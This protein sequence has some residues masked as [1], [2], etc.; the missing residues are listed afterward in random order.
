MGR[1]ELSDLPD[2]D[3]QVQAFV[4]TKNAAERPVLRV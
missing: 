3:A 4:S 2:L 1:L